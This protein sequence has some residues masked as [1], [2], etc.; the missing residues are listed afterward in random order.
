MK[1]TITPEDNEFLIELIKD[2]EK[3]SKKLLKKLG[4]A[5]AHGGAFVGKIPEY[6]ELTEKINAL[7]EKE[8]EVKKILDNSKIIL[9]E[10]MEENVIG[11]YSIVTVKNLESEE[12]ITYYL[13]EP[14]LGGGKISERNDFLEASLGSPIGSALSG[15]KVGDIVTINLPKRKVKFKIV[16]HRKH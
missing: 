3:E 13:I 16:S 11:H 15:K 12:E 1:I 6:D 14:L 2:L 9:L 8:N 7:D 10:E 5:A 4:E